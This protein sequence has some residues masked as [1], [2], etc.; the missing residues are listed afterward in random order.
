MSE[1]ATSKHMMDEVRQ[2]NPGME[3]PELEVCLKI[4]NDE[5][6]NNAELVAMFRHHVCL[7]AP[8]IAEKQVD[9]G[10][11]KPD[12]AIAVLRERISMLSRQNLEL[13]S[14]LNHF[15]RLV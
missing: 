6:A 10:E 8:M 2:D 4:L 15:R 14:I 11:I 3:L 12:G 7:L 13:K 1:F 9:H 5:I